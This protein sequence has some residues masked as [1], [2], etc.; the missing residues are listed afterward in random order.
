MIRDIKKGLE[1]ITNNL[2]NLNQNKPKQF[3]LETSSNFDRQGE[4][5]I[6]I[7]EDVGRIIGYNISSNIDKA[8]TLEIIFYKD[9]PKKVV[10]IEEVNGKRVKKKKIITEDRKL[11]IFPSK[12][13]GDKNKF[14]EYLEEFSKAKKLRLDYHSSPMIDALLIGPLKVY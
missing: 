1:D 2:N 5:L 14:V 13:Q 6:Y 9:M 12:L 3:Y 10:E 4:Y 7:K 11:S 8:V